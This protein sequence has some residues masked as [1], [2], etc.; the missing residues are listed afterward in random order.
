[1]FMKFSCSFDSGKVLFD[2]IEVWRIGREKQE[3]CSSLF[4]EL[5]GF[6][7]LMKRGIVHHHHMIGLQDWTK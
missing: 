5:L 4:N 6:V 3:C 7:G 1:M 2:G